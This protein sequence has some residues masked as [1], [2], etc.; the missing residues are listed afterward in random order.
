MKTKLKNLNKGFTI[1]E[2]MIVLAIA[3]LI[4]AIVFLAVPQLQRNSRD[5]ARQSIVNRMKAELDTY[6]S[7]NQGRYPFATTCTGGA[8]GTT[9]EWCNF[10]NR[11]INGKVNIEDP[12][13]GTNVVGAAP[14]NSVCNSAVGTGCVAPY[15]SG[16]NVP[17]RAGKFAVIYGAKCNGENVTNSGSPSAN[18]KNYVV[19]IGLDRDNTV[20]CVDNG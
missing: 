16:M 9:G 1:I 6:S 5:N 19:M 10:Y 17:D 12:S 4:L 13:S 11:Y 15:L 3:G 8:N 2:V 14:S 18:S 20:Y 7:N